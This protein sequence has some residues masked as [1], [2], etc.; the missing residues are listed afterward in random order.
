[1]PM[2]FPSA[3]RALLVV[4]LAICVTRPAH[5]QSQGAVAENLFREGKK[6]L[7]ERRFD[8][9]CQKFRES[10]RLDLSSGV[11]LALGLCLEGQGK[12]A[13]AWGA[14]LSAASLAHHDR[15]SDREGA[16][17][18]RA[19]ALEPKLSHATIEVVPSTAALRGLEVR[20]DSVLLESPAW[21]NA[22]I[23]VGPHTL[24]VTAPGKKTFSRTYVVAA[25]GAAV[26]VSIPELE[27]VPPPPAAVVPV[28]S[29]SVASGAWR[30]P[31]GLVVGGV[32]VVALGA[33]AILGAI[34]LSDAAAVHKVC[35]A[36]PC[37]NPS[38]RSENQT[39]ETLADAST[40]LFVLAG[41][42]LA[43]GTALF[44]TSPRKKEAATARVYPV[45]GPTSLGVVGRW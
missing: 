1:M 27:D 33:G 36:G 9:A 35:S 19:S 28:T 43:T 23:D 13:S 14:Y 4:S 31:V 11:E 39:A 41:V 3:V 24:D 40:T 38:I 22:P 37:A 18:A 45:I 20:Q 30:K 44:L 34:T 8:E 2:R 42:T 25:N 16:A 29:P 5:A 26:T 7:E 10:A 6:L 12:L 32:G 21:I 17:K 15:R